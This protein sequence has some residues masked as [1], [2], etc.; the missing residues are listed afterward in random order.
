MNARPSPLIPDIEG[1]EAPTT[2]R[3]LYNLLIT[4]P[5]VR[6]RPVG[7]ERYIPQGG[8]KNFE[9]LQKSPS[10]P[11]LPTLC[12]QLFSQQP[13]CRD[14]VG[15]TPVTA[16]RRSQKPADGMQH[17][18]IDARTYQVG[19]F[20]RLSTSGLGTVSAPANNR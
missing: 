8:C 1:L 6:G 16:V 17:Q 2:R 11:P 5:T 7:W 4:L 3:C 14:F 18:G 10:N 20:A 13:G 12:I 19:P 9:K 15:P